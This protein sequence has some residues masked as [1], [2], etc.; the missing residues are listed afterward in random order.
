M[1]DICTLLFAT[2]CATAGFCY[3]KKYEQYL[4]IT[5]FQ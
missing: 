3:K 4:V 5:C 1:N 2:V